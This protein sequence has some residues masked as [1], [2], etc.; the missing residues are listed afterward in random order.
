M[1]A[2]SPEMHPGIP[3]GFSGMLVLLVE[4]VISGRGGG[5]G[6]GG[7]RNHLNS[8]R[9]KVSA[10]SGKFCEIAGEAFSLSFLYKPFPVF[11]R[12]G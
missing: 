12:P 6:G 8:H 9:D 4:Q 11:P 7:Y 10:G 5:R 2:L 1:C 3:L